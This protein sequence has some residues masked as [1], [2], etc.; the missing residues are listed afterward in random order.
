MANF[1]SDISWKLKTLKL[2]PNYLT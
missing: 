2:R 1:E